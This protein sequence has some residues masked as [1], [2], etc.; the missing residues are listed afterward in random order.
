MLNVDYKAVEVG[1]ITANTSDT[2][3]AG[4]PVRISSSTVRSHN[5]LAKCIGLIK[6]SRVSGVVNEI[7]GDYGIYGSGK[8]TVVMNGVVQVKQS[9][10]SGTSYAVYDE[11]Q[12]YL[13]GQDLWADTDG[14]ITN[15]EPSGV[16][17]S[18]LT[19]Q[20]V[21]YVIAPP[22]NGADGDA[23]VLRVDR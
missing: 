21:G 15:Q 1:N 12:T 9:T 4:R 2:F 7:D 8:A 6:E 18:G 14:Y 3:L 20:R 22:T 13:S 23:M 16:A 17:W 10:Y 19:G 5:G 11:A